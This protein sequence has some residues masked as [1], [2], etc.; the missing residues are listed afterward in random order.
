MRQQNTALMLTLILCTLCTGPAAA[1]ELMLPGASFTTGSPVDGI[2]IT[3]D[4]DLAVAAYGGKLCLIDARGTLCGTATVG[5]V[6]DLAVSPDGKRIA[7]ASEKVRVFD[8]DLMEVWSW[9]NGYFAY[10][11]A[12]LEGGEA[13]VAGFDDGTL[14][15]LNVG[16]GEDWTITL[17]ADPVRVAATPDGSYVIAGIKTGELC[18]FTGAQRELWRYRLGA[19]PVSAVA[20]SDDAGT[21][22]VASQ[23]DMLFVFNKNGRLL[24]DRPAGAMCDLAVSSDGS[25]VAAGGDTVRIFA[26]NGTLLW[27]EPSGPPDGAVALSG[28]GDALVAGGNGAVSF[29]HA[30]PPASAAF[31]APETSAIPAEPAA[32]EKTATP[33][34]T[35]AAWLSVPCVLAAICLALVSLRR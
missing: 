18:F 35:D 33:E 16:G 22:A 17:D 24:W 2:A 31:P 29:F 15:R 5:T 10:G 11:I 26:R 30:R 4:G 12:F 13:I 20:V 23:D 7:V 28:D 27:E 9:D 19:Q 3:H 34:P 21:I 1:D 25:L 14:R 6:Q 8:K 32:P